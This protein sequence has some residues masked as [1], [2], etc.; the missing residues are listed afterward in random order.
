MVHRMVSDTTSSKM[1][2]L[3]HLPNCVTHIKKEKFSIFT[4]KVIPNTVA[5]GTGKALRA[6]LLNSKQN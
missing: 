2:N 3:S 6:V 5:G 4:L 1:R